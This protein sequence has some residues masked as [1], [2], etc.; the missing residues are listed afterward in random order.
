[1]LDAIKPLLDNGIINEE[2]KVAIGEAWESRITEAKEQVRAE[3]REEFAQRY[4]HDKQVMVEALDKMVTESLTAELQEFA[5]EKKQLA[6]DRVAFKQQMVESAGKF[7]NFMVAK[8]AEEIKELR[9][10]RKTY[11]NAIS[12]LESFTIRALAEEIKEFEADKKAVVETKVRLVAEGKAK[13]AELQAKFVK[14]SAE[15]VKEAVSSSLES[16][17]TQLKED[18]QIARENMFGRRLFEAFAS[19]FAGTHLNENK[20]IRELQGTVGTLSQKLSEAVQKIEEKNVL[21]ESKEREVRIIKESAE[22]KEKLAEML[23]PLNKEKS[24]I[25]RDLLESVQTDKLQSSYEKYLP[26][27]LNNSPVAKPAAKVALTESRV[28]VTGDKTAKTAVETSE[29]K[30]VMSNV[31]EMK[32]LAGLK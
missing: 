13:L 7:N 1:M 23:K 25:M 22:R 12:K 18:I 32:R 19:E 26:A 16:E 5:D 21:V 30:D 8:L 14:Q 20:Q 15:A 6:E 29:T 4:Q 10:D 27:V 11:E 2:T 9:A 17:L 3:L 28:E 24:A 31:Y